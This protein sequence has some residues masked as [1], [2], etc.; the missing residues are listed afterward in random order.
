[1]WIIGHNSKIFNEAQFISKA[2]VWSRVESNYAG[3]ITQ[4]YQSAVHSWA[5]GS[6]ERRK[7]DVGDQRSEDGGRKDSW[8]SQSLTLLGF[9]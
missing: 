1:M 6:Q 9:V 7:E 5:V 3:D 4:A 8:Q 2:E